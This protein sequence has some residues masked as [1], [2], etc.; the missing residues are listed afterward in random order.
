MKEH[1]I[2]SGTFTVDKESWR[3]HMKVERSKIW[4][5]RAGLIR[6]FLTV[7]INF[8]F[9]GG[10]CILLFIL[11]TLPM[12]FIVKTFMNTQLSYNW[13]LALSLSSLLIYVVT[14]VF[15]CFWWEDDGS[16][17]FEVLKH[18]WNELDRIP[19]DI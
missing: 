11:W 1:L 8:V 6:M 10:S 17:R 16:K 4:K 5:H 15:I 12:I 19:G 13:K 9:A 7:P 14:S 18:R 2:S 3:K